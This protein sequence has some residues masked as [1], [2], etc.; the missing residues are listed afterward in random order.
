M[1]VLANYAFSFKPNHGLN[2]LDKRDAFAGLA[3]G[4]DQIIQESAPR[5]SLWG[6]VRRPV[7]P[8]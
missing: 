2:V 6:A 5:G 3:L 1:G 4:F 8:E 7:R